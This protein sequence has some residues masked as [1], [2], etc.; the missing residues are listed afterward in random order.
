MVT[1]LLPRR[2]DI[3][4]G[5]EIVLL[6][7]IETLGG[8]ALVQADV[9]SF[10][11]TL[12]DLDATIPTTAVI[13]FA[14]VAPALGFYDTLQHDDAENRLGDI[15]GYNFKYTISGTYTAAMG[16]HNMVVEVKVLT[17]ANGTRTHIQEVV[18]AGKFS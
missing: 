1:R 17:V 6:G 3:K 14:A 16:G 10:T 12:Y 7:R 5:E 15:I 11:V 13:A 4:E 8:T 18:V 2:I 9:T